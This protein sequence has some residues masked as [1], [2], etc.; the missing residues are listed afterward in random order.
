MDNASLIP[1]TTQ[2]PHLII[3]EW[4]PRLKDVELRVLLV[5]A[6][7]TLGWVEDAETGRRKERDWISQYLL[8]KKISRSDRA[9]QKALHKLI[10]ELR[11][12]Q[13]Y[14]EQG[15]LLDSS[16][17]R[18]KCG[19][20]IFYRLS[21]RA[22]QP[23]LFPL[24][25]ERSSGVAH[26]GKKFTQPPKN[27]R[28][29]KVRATKETGFTNLSLKTSELGSD[30]NKNVD[31]PVD[32]SSDSQDSQLSQRPKESAPT[33]YF[34]WKFGQLSK[35]I[36]NEKPVFVK[37]KDGKLITHALG[38]LN[39]FQLELELIW[40]LQ[41]KPTMKPCFGAALCKE[42]IRDFIKASYREYGFYGN[43]ERTA[44]RYSTGPG[45]GK[46]EKTEDETGAM[47][48]MVDALKKLKESFGV[49]FSHEVRMQI[50]EET[51][52]MER[53]ARV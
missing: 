5:V 17:K 29:K 7:Q 21:L 31:N 50:A 28:A 23:M 19:G 22:P 42:V 26:H 47:T 51:A 43:L 40:F 4:M 39:E 41:N 13:A 14:D 30:S 45:Q 34:F 15:Q 8:M 49:P 37:F 46:R 36:R 38:H 53:A 33:R 32:N 12:V 9:V 44:L 10:D 6:D 3:R 2:I 25:P 48:A 20:K 27:L 11:I 24:T 18:M 52:S 1:N 35:A 16:Q